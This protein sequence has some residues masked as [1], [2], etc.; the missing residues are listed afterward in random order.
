MSGKDGPDY[1]GKLWD[2]AKSESGY[3]S[4]INSTSFIAGQAVGG[5]LGKIVA[6]PIAKLFDGISAANRAQREAAEE[7]AYHQ[8][9]FTGTETT[10]E[11]LKRIKLIT[12]AITERPTKEEFTKDIFERFIQAAIED[13]DPI[14]H[15][16]FPTEPLIDLITGLYQPERIAPPPQPSNKQPI[17]QA[18]YR[19]E[20]RAFISRYENP[21][22]ILYAFR[23]LAMRTL[24][25]L[26]ADLPPHLQKDGE[27]EPHSPFTLP[28][29]DQLP[30]PA[31]SI[32]DLFAIFTDGKINKLPN[33]QDI[34]NQL[35]R[36][37]LTVSGL[38]IEEESLNSPKLVRPADYKGTAAE[39]IYHYTDGTPFQQF[40]SSPIPFSIPDDALSEH[41]LVIASTGTGKS[42]LIQADVYHYLQREQ[43]PGIVIIDSQGTMLPKFEHL[44]LWSD[45][46]IIIDPEDPTP[47]AL[48]M[49]ALPERIQHYDRNT[50]EKIESD[51]V[52]LFSFIF[53]A[54]DQNLTG[55]QST[56]FSFVTRLVLSIPNATIRT[57]REVLEE[58]VKTPQQSQFWPHIEKLDEDAKA[59]FTSQFFQKGYNVETKRG[60]VQRLYGILRVPAFNRMFTPGGNRLDLFKELNAGRTV[61]VSTSKSLLGN[62]ASSV[63]GRYIV[64]QT[65]SAAFQ[66][67]AIKE[68][69]PLA[70]IYIDEA[71]DYFQD[72]TL[73]ALFTQARKFNLGALI[74][75]QNLDQLPS[76]IRPEILANTATKL[77][78]GLEPGDA[79]SLAQSMRTTPEFL[80]SLRKHKAGSEFACYIKNH[81]PQAVKL[82]VP[83][84]VIEEAPKMSAGEHKALRQKNRERYGTRE[85]PAEP[86]P[87]HQP[88]TPAP[89]K[90]NTATPP[91]AKGPASDPHA[92]IDD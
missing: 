33:A 73:A 82:T 1:W 47:P 11:L 69:Y 29:Y 70:L 38:P 78:A 55:R 75:F 71:D 23:Y 7:A 45:D 52:Q 54:L 58:D 19:D 17:T 91:P 26:C 5:L 66:R 35:F 31:Q 83:F 49:L 22:D 74:A 39:L 42:Q 15:L 27:F 36:N 61:L 14:F 87:P 24:Y 59:F 53:A 64:A 68:P 6:W 81:I 90:A 65:L 77:V 44:N 85:R 86:K 67:I 92:G 40:Y 48:N 18:L 10:E 34:G 8:A 2:R 43:R 63:F 79:R 41:R 80:L 56:F 32:S 57:L 20:L 21:E 88:Q 12:T 37:L 72:A 84:G 3:T 25:S 76:S 60:I 30:Y 89:P 46:L 51:A 62:D 4:Y 13:K 9:L 50:R 28:L 16:D